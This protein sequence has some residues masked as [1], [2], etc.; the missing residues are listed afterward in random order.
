[1]SLANEIIDEIAALFTAP[2]GLV[3][4]LAWNSTI[5]DI[6]NSYFPGNDSAIVSKI[7]Y[8]I[9]VTVIAVIIAV[10]IGT[11]S[12]KAQRTSDKV[13][14]KGVEKVKKE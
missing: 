1:M 11:L 6:F 2:F 3:A 12:S 7:T 13:K 10:V 5:Q 4:A 9:V 14:D 8:A